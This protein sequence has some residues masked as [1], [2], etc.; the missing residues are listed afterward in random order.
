MGTKLSRTIG[1][2]EEETVDKLIPF[3]RDNFELCCELIPEK[4]ELSPEQFVLHMKRWNKVLTI[5]FVPLSH[6]S[7]AHSKDGSGLLQVGCDQ[8]IISKAESIQQARFF[9]LSFLLLSYFGVL[10]IKRRIGERFGVPVP[11]VMLSKPFRSLLSQL[12]TVLE[13]VQS[14]HWV[15]EKGRSKTNLSLFCFHSNHFRMLIPKA[16]PPKVPGK[17]SWCFWLF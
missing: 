3:L 12:S 15:R 17:E 10:Q 14:V 7:N 2:A 13:A 1:G 9:L 16:L 6:S 4:E 8:M 5:S 11:R